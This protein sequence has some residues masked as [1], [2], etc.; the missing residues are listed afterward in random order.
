MAA[1]I[2]T[3]AK[4][5]I[6]D[7][8]LPPRKRFK[9]S[10]LPLNA[11]QRSSIDG[12][13]HTIKKK[14]KYDS[15]RQ[16]VWSQ[17]AESEEKAAFTKSLNELAEAEIDRDPS[18]LSRDRGKAATLMQGAVD[19]SDIYKNVE[20][21]L[22]ELIAK[23]IHHIIEAGREIRLAE[24]GEE[25]AAEEEKRGSRT[26]EQYERE[27]VNKRQERARARK[28]E[29]ARKRREE[30]KEALRAQE[31]QKMKELEKLR[32][33]DEKRK[34]REAVKA[35][36]AAEKERR[37]PQAMPKDVE[38]RKPEMGTETSQDQDAPVDSPAVV[39]PPV[40]EK[41]LEEAALALLLQ[42][43]REAA[44]KNEKKIDRDLSES[45]HRKPHVSPPKGPAAMRARDPTKPRLGFSSAPMHQGS[46]I[47]PPPPPMHPHSRSPYR[48]DRSRSTSQ[49]RR[50]SHSIRD[51]DDY[52]QMDYKSQSR[53]KR[54]SEAGIHDSRDEDE[55]YERSASTRDRDGRSRKHGYDYEP[56]KHDYDHDH[57]ESRESYSR[58]HDDGHRGGGRYEERRSS[59]T[60]PPREE[61]P[62]HIDRYVPGGAAP[63]DRDKERERDPKERDTPREPRRDRSSYFD[64]DRERQYYKKESESGRS[65]YR[66]RDRGSD[67]HRDR[68]GY[69]D[70][71]RRGH[72]ER[73][74]VKPRT[75]E[76]PEHIDRYV[77][78]K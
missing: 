51:D 49:T 57:K 37:R 22:D 70:R 73:P 2:A 29:E 5:L 36:R 16:R 38:E 4:H 42:E 45:P 55:H 21:A 66:D 74:Y 34:E 25:V 33:Q 35:A 46:P 71:D 18:L 77:P 11:A 31:A 10:E 23:N 40:D 26:D 9:T 8:A 68:D 56:S 63:R 62:E 32:S 30:E 47:P 7:P 67:R 76:P 48:L 61:A 41:A 65:S 3:T 1:P 54:H 28:Q 60:R 12:L 59:Y 27:A 24:V 39:V 17:F 44:A 58:R 69:R 13:L 75:D 14:G 78:G 72:G 20:K 52:Y 43:G 53:A 15:L 6:E 50:G 64:T 19:R